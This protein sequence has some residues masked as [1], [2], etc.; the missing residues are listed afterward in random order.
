L[1]PK[2][3]YNRQLAYELAKM[4]QSG[5]WC[6]G[7]TFEM[8]KWRH[9]ASAPSQSQDDNSE[10]E[11]ECDCGS[12]EF[13]DYPM[14]GVKYGLDVF[15]DMADARSLFPEMFPEILFPGKLFQETL[16]TRNL[17]PE[18]LLPD[19]LFPKDAFG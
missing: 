14:V 1:W 8:V 5:R 13:V 7:V 12:T 19:K 9:C 17:F 4:F 16:F 3:Q 11:R 15:G 10:E 6:L 2:E 18:M